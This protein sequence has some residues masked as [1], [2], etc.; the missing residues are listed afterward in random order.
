MKYVNKMKN[1]G[2]IIVLLLFFCFIFPQSLLKA[3]KTNRIISLIPSS[4]EI[5]F[6]IGYGEEVIA[7]SNY[8][9]YPA[10]EIDGL[11]KIGDQNLNIEKI[12]S[13]KPTILVDTNGIH[14][15]YEAIFNKLHLNYVNLSIKQLEDIPLEAARLAEMLGNK[16]KAD[17]FIEKWNL[18]ISRLSTNKDMSIPKIYMEIWNN[19]I[20][21][22]G[23]NNIMDSIITTAGGKNAL[24]NIKDFPVVNSEIL[25][26]ANPDIIILAYPD[27]N[28][29]SVKK[30]PGWKSI[31]AV[32]NNQIFAINQDTIVRP[33]PRN[34]EAIKEINN[35]I[36]KVEKQ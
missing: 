14:K 24:E 17:S 10:K 20:Q 28:I 16:N 6:A 27:A 21:A 18:E 5:I 7:V 13:L 29:E 25:M 1:K 26:V 4:T 9:N 33:S 3:E 2:S 22:V 23:G 35:Y 8:C 32:K 11:P 15:K 12:I 36:N 19:P 34:I 31:K 30:R